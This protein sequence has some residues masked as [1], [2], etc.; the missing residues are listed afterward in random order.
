MSNLEDKEEKQIRLLEVVR[1][2]WQ[3]DT[4]KADW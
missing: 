4:G 1:T 3:R 2:K